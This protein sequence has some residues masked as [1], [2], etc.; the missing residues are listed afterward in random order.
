MLGMTLEFKNDAD[1]M[2]VAACT[3]CGLGTSLLFVCLLNHY[4]LCG[5]RAHGSASRQEITL[6][7]LWMMFLCMSLVL[8]LN[9][10]MRAKVAFYSLVSA[11]LVF[12]VS[13]FRELSLLAGFFLIVL[14]LMSL[15]SPESRFWRRFAVDE[16]EAGSGD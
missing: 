14:C 16:G 1:R 15:R 7:V 12:S 3:V 6:D 4:C 10:N 9:S 11:T 8:T 13:N 2:R 5:H